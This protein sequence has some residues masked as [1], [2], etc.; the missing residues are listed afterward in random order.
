MFLD[1]H[2]TEK[3]LTGRRFGRLVAV[4]YVERNGSQK[5]WLCQCDC[6]QTKKIHKGSLVRGLTQSCGCAKGDLISAKR[7]RH[8][9][10]RVNAASPEY[11]TWSA[12]KKRCF[13]EKDKSYTRY[14]G[15]G[16]GVYAAWIDDFETFLRDVGPRPSKD[17]SLDR[18][19]NDKGYEPKNVRWATRVEQA[20][21]KRTSV[22]ITAFGK[23]MTLA[24]WS[25]ETGIKIGTIWAR[26]KAGATPEQSLEPVSE[27]P[28]NCRLVTHNGETKTVADWARSS[29]FSAWVIYRRLSAGWS[30]RD[31]VTKPLRKR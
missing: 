12:M 6:G 20:N 3:D 7:T 14:G 29:G 16:I 21:N 4:G 19:K 26:L 18:I 11:R 30:E 23:A 22:H 31:A 25:R 10:A 9:H 8:G 1:L 24:E 15:R 13:D 5:L 27:D 17:H 2:P 28:W